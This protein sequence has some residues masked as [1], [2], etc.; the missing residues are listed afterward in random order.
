[1]SLRKTSHFLCAPPTRNAVTN[2]EIWFRAAVLPEI[3]RSNHRENQPLP[4]P[5]A[6]KRSRMF[7][8]PAV[9]GGASMKTATSGEPLPLA[10]HRCTVSSRS[11]NARLSF[12]A[13]RNAPIPP[14]T[15]PPFSSDP[16]RFRRVQELVRHPE[17]LGLFREAVRRF[18]TLPLKKLKPQK[19][20]MDQAR[21]RSNDQI[22]KRQTQRLQCKSYIRTS[23]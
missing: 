17:F 22:A 12:V 9:G 2:P 8:L 13:M 11:S 10:I 5:R 7:L 19:P 23:A 18:Q 20:W 21:V 16:E 15:L 14:V 1:V 3:A 4:P 6:R